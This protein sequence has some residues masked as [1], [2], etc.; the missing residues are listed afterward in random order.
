MN[1]FINLIDNLNKIHK[2]VVKIKY[3]YRTHWTIEVFEDGYDQA[4]ISVNSKF[5]GKAFEDATNK[6]LANYF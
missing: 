5:K 1:D 2:L 3:S 4:L 6:L